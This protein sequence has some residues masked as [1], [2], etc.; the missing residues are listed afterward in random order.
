MRVTIGDAAK[1]IWV[2]VETLRLWEK[3]GKIKSER[4]QGNHNK[5]IVDTAKNMFVEKG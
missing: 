2:T 3:A 5:S 1:E 4:T